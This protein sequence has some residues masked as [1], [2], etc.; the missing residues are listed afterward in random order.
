MTHHY[1][2]VSCRVVP[3]CADV[4]AMAVPVIG[5]HAGTTILPLLS[6]VRCTLSSLHSA[7]LLP[8]IALHCTAQYRT[9]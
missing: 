9:P 2:V 1:H 5:G 4:N 6:Q 8:C 3:G 7:S